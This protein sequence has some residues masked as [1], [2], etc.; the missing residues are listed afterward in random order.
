MRRVSSCVCCVVVVTDTQWLSG[1]QYSVLALGDTNYSNFCKPGVRL[2]GELV[3]MGAKRW[4]PL[5]CADDGTSLEAVVEPWKDQVKTKLT[6]EA[7]APTATAAV[8][9][10]E[11]ATAAAHTSAAAPISVSASSVFSSTASD[12]SSSADTTSVQFKQSATAAAIQ[13]AQQAVRAM[14][15]ARSTGTQQSLAISSI[16][17]APTQ[18]TLTST[19]SP[20]ASALLP[21]S[22]SLILFATQTGNSEAVARELHTLYSSRFT[23][24]P[25]L[26]SM[27]QYLVTNSS[28]LASLSAQYP[29][30]TIV[31][32]ST[33]DG[34]PPDNALRF[35]RLLKKQTDSEGAH[36]LS[37]LQY[38]ILGLGDSYVRSFWWWKYARVEREMV[39]WWWCEVDGAMVCG[40]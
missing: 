37:G 18:S 14:Q 6:A 27:P 2:D 9:A 40:G 33:A 22:Q 35:L 3:R 1:C 25:T 17:H 30:V 38:V 19:P 5:A 20:T 13:Q 28:S 34:Q 32:S 15:L 21:L 7:G 36:W 10:Q 8:T 11:P 23:P 12:G 24:Q 39:K 26:L 31:C 16:G 29:L 4:L